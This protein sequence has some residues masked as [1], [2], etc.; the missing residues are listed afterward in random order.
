MHCWPGVEL[1]QQFSN[2]C[3]PGGPHMSFKASPLIVDFFLS[4]PR[5]ANT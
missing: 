1:P 2:I 4:H 3:N 5:Q